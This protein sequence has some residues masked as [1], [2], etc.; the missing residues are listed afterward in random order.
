MTAPVTVDE[1]IT[2]LRLSF[3]AT[4]DERLEITRMLEAATTYAEQYTRRS[5]QETTRIEYF[6]EFPATADYSMYLPG[7][8][9]SSI[10]SVTYYDSTPTQQTWDSVEYR[11]L[12]LGGRA[13]LLPAI[14]E[15]YPS[16]CAGEKA[17]I[18]VTYVAGL[19]ALNV[20][21]GVKAAILLIVGSLYEY[22]EDGVI[23]NAGLAVVKAP[24]AANRLLHPYKASL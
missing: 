14:G 9:L 4:V 17:N 1:A 5:W 20:P 22:R 19:T 11:T 15:Q 2:H 7:G 21:E 3:D 23:D 16:D 18:E 10:T 8:S 24:V 12:S 6:D 13:Y